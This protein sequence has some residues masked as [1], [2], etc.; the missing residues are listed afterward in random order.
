[1]DFLPHFFNQLW[2]LV[3]NALATLAKHTFIPYGWIEALASDAEVYKK[4]SDSRDLKY[5]TKKHRML[6]Q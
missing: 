6:W 1:M 2:K 5:Q 3:K 4:S